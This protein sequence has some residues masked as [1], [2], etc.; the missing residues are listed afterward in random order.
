M[1]LHESLAQSVA[2]L[3]GIGPQSVKRLEKL[4]IHSVQDLLFHLPHR[5]EDRTKIYPIGSLSA[6]MSVLTSGI[7]EF[8]DVLLKGRHSLITRISDHTGSLSLRFFH[9][10]AKQQ[11]NLSPGTLISCFGEVRQGYQGLEIIHPEYKLI[12]ST[13]NITE[14]CLT[15]IYPLTEGLR[16]ATLRKAIK[17]AISICLEQNHLLTDYLPEQILSQYHYPSFSDDLLSLH[18]PIEDINA[19]MLLQGNLPALKRLVFE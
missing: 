9:F 3:T 14:S 6:G 5:Y 11:L 15:P 2:S 12:S 1:S 7:I 8:T 13:D 4:G 10:S 17:Q 16:Q 18:S 19:E